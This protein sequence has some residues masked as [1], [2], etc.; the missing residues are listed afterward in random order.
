MVTTIS[1]FDGFKER[2]I[3]AAGEAGELGDVCA[4]AHV[5][6]TKLRRDNGGD[7]CAH[8]MTSLAIAAAAH[9]PQA[10]TEKNPVDAERTRKAQE[11][12]ATLFNNMVETLTKAYNEEPI[13]PG[14]DGDVMIEGKLGS[15]W[16]GEERCLRH[17]K[18]HVNTLAATLKDMI[19]GC[20]LFA[21]L[22]MGGGLVDLVKTM[23]ADRKQVER[24]LQEEQGVAGQPNPLETGTQPA[25]EAPKADEAAPAEAPA[26]VEAPAAEEPPAQEPTAEQPTT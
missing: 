24:K 11:E 3:K 14:S 15:E 12:S 8:I 10:G 21:M 1:K 17:I 7:A 19:P 13:A 6:M 2:I 26:Q 9:H 5:L 22:S 16:T 18:E 4:V 23:A 20:R 25:P